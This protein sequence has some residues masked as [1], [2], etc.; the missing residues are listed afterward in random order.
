MKEG[1]YTS[2]KRKEPHSQMTAMRNG[3]NK[4]KEAGIQG[5]VGDQEKADKALKTVIATY[6][7]VE[8]IGEE[9]ANSPTEMRLNTPWSGWREM[10]YTKKEKRL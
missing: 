9:P 5:T 7:S 8:K 6:S 10:K 4:K 2:R 3:R 1:K